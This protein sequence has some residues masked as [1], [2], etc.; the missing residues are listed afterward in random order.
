MKKPE[1][2]DIDLTK[3]IKELRADLHARGLHAVA[4]C[5]T[6]KKIPHAVPLRREDLPALAGPDPMAGSF[7]LKLLHSRANM[8]RFLRAH[9]ELLSV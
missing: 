2:P 9:P 5:L 6:G 4:D 8:R 7:D 3:P 1:L